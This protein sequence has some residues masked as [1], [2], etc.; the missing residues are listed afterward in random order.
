MITTA[1]VTDGWGRSLEHL[2]DNTCQLAIRRSVAEDAPRIVEV[3]DTVCAE[4]LFMRTNRYVPTPAWERA[5]RAPDEHLDHVILLAMIS[6]RIVG[7]CQVYPASDD[8]G[9]VGIGILKPY[10]EH[11][12][13]TVLMTQAIAWAGAQGLARLTADCFVTNARSIHLFQKLGFAIVGRCRFAGDTQDSALLER[14]L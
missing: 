9:D 11:G 2:T 14:R 8:T 4:R 5:L 1:R 13:G 3:V 10:R 7:W 6:E 12:I